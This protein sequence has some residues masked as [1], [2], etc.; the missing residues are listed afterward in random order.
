MRNQQFSGA[1]L[2]ELA[3]QKN[4]FNKRM[5]N[6]DKIIDQLRNEKVQLAQVLETQRQNFKF[7][8]SQQENKSAQ[9]IKELKDS[10][11]HMV[12]QLPA[13]QEKLELYKQ[14][15]GCHQLLLSEEA[16]IDLR[17][18]QNQSLKEFIQVKVYETLMNYR[19]DTEKYQFEN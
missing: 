19:R 2:G 12:D 14:E 1:L 15:L 6:Q 9:I 13:F 16:Y 17:V 5:I 8:L 18:K 11:K 7:A 10:Q 3:A 4:K